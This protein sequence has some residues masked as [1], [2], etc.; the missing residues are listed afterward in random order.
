MKNVCWLKESEAE[1]G[2]D[3]TQGAKAWLK[4]RYLQ[5]VA[6]QNIEISK[7]VLLVLGNRGGPDLFQGSLCLRIN[8]DR[9]HGVLWSNQIQTRMEKKENRNKGF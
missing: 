3:H 4:R 9:C 2:P 8:F 6:P 7:A 5:Y 1:R